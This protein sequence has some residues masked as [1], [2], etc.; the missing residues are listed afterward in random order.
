MCVCSSGLLRRW[1]RRGGV[2]VLR[3]SRPLSSLP[4]LQCPLSLP[5][6][7]SDAWQPLTKVSS[8]TEE[9]KREKNIDSG[10]KRIKSIPWGNSATHYLLDFIGDTTHSHR[11]SFP[12]IGRK[13]SSKHVLEITVIMFCCLS[14]PRRQSD[15]RRQRGRKRGRQQSILFSCLLSG[16]Y[17]CRWQNW[18]QIPLTIPRAPLLWGK[19]AVRNKAWR[20][21]LELAWWGND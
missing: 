12:L 18:S 3:L 2:T 10:G 13:L 14:V 21:G 9:L 1:F 5:L 4:P 19:R 11:T 17:V 20:W 7:P 6:R 16:L 8:C 15:I